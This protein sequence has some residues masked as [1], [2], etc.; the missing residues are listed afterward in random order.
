MSKQRFPDPA[1][2]RPGQAVAPG[3]SIVPITYPYIIKEVL[4]DSVI[5]DMNHPLAGQDLHY[6]VHILKV[7]A[8]TPEE[9]EPLKKCESCKTD[10]ECQG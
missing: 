8:A 10:S 4:D 1:A 6:S 2:L 7:R 9:I 3:N 5:L